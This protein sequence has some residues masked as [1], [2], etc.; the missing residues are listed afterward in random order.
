MYTES[1]RI[2]EPGTLT[3]QKRTVTAVHRD[4]LMARRART[5]QLITNSAV[6]HRG[7]YT[8]IIAKNSSCFRDSSTLSRSVLRTIVTGRQGLAIGAGDFIMCP[9]EGPCD[10]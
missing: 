4:L 1:V 6:R 5:L 8:A 7:A 2:A 3:M 9:F 10:G